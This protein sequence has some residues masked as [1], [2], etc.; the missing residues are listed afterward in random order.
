[1]PKQLS[2]KA[3]SPKDLAM[4]VLKA[5]REQ[6]KNAYI[7]MTLDHAGLTEMIMQTSM[8]KDEKAELLSEA[9]D[10]VIRHRELAGKSF[11]RTI[12]DGEAAG[13]NWSKAIYDK[14]DVEHKHKDGIE[15]CDLDIRFTSSGQ[16]YT[17][18]LR[19]VF[20]TSQGW[21]IGG[22]LMFG[23][24]KEAKKQMEERARAIADSITTALEKA[25]NE[26]LTDTLKK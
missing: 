16:N 10:L 1:M 2:I 23:S 9:N 5:L 22:S 20:K 15:G 4:A 14:A 3:G 11:L 26:N 25:V 17:V 8:N 7:G 21:K 13:L 18:S 24:W 6:D 12:S 19:D